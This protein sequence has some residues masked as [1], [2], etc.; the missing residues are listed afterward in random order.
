MSN[1]PFDRTIIHELEKP[2][3]D[4]INQLE[5]NFDQA[6]RFF[7]AALFS[8][9]DTGTP[10]DG[11][12]GTGLLV[13]AA[14]P[15]NMSV[16]VIAG[17]GFQLQTSIEPA[18]DSVPGL[19]DLSTYKPIP[20]NANQVFTVPVAPVAPN[21][22]VDIIEV[23]ADRIT[24]DPSLRQVFDEILGQFV[25]DTLNK[26]LA[27]ALDGRAAQ[28]NAPS[29]S[30]APLSYVVGQAANPGLPPPTTPG[31]IKLAEISVGSDVVAIVPANITDFRES[32]TSRVTKVSMCPTSGFPAGGVSPEVQNEGGSVT[33]ADFNNWAVNIIGLEAGDVVRDIVTVFDK[34]DG[35]SSNIRVN[36]FRTEVD[37]D[38]LTSSVVTL[39]NASATPNPQTALGL[40]KISYAEQ[41]P[42]EFPFTWEEG[43]SAT[44]RFHSDASLT[45]DLLSVY[46]IVQRS[47][48]QRDL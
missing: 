18:I 11:F 31:Y 10:L 2:L 35:T 38:A 45:V 22:R 43:W 32:L 30:T 6:L 37:I 9:P 19:N 24:T 48:I 29:P 13:S 8:N 16:S 23:K 39:P 26:T 21:T 1:R 4:D 14:S 44:L 5:T 27:W 3:A 7:L 36:L 42:A 15:A 34:T 46:A 12:L 40:Y 25:P 33:V 28:I 20:L 17:L 41:Q 47:T